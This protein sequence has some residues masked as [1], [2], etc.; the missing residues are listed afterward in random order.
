[1]RPLS[2][3]ELRKQAGRFVQTISKEH[4]SELYGVTDGK[5]VGTYIEK[6]FKSHLSDNFELSKGSAA[7][8]IDLVDPEL[9][10]DIKFTKYTQPQSSSPYKS[11]SQKVYGLGHNLLVFVYE[12]SDIEKTKSSV[13]VIHNCVF[14]D[15]NRTADYSLTKIILE[16]LN[17]DGNS[18]DI[19]SLLQEKKLPLNEIECTDLAARIISKPPT[20]G[21]LT[22]S[23]ALQ[24][25]LQYGRSLKSADKVGG[26]Y[27]CR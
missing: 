17:Q 23:N 5:A 6:L 26:I 1:M 27:N 16:I 8:G 24:W 20:Q 7:K 14:I 2:L 19:V 22:I 3:S 13:V 4:H 15:A 25:R 18:D 9:N 11:A 12:K 21:Y 10:T